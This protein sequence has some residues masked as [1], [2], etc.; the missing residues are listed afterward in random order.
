[1]RPVQIGDWEPQSSSG[2]FRG[3]VDLRTAFAASINTVAAQLGETVGVPAVIA[4]AR[5]L[6]IQ[7][8]LPAVPSLALGSAEVTL[9]EM[10]RAF[11]SVATDTAGLDAYAVQ[12]ITN[13]SEANLYRRAAPMPAGAGL[14]EARASLLEALNAVVES[15]TG[16]AAR[17]PGT[18]VGGKTGTTQEYRDAWFIGFTPEITVGVWLGNDDNSPTD[19][20]AGGELPATIWN[21]FVSRALPVLARRGGAAPTRVAARSAVQTTGSTASLP[22]AAAPTSLR[23]TPTVLDT[24]TLALGGRPLRLQGVAGEPGRMARQLARF[25]ADREVSCAPAEGDLY[26]CE[27]DGENLAGL[28]LAAGGARASTDADPEL[29]AAEDQARSARLGIWRR[30]R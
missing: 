18:A 17:L 22:G 9:F 25:L 2:R 29:L 6:G 5:R 20:V 15:G 19:H 7:S 10:T 21:D 11:A 3:R 28:I 13:G 23:G 27:V 12:A 4:T 24:G 30:G 26:R 1:D 16:R 8:D 14:G